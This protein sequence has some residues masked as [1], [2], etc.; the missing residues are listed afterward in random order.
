MGAKFSFLITSVFLE[1]IS[2]PNLSLFP[3]QV[4]QVISRTV[5]PTRG[6]QV[7]VRLNCVQEEPRDPQCYSTIVVICVLEGVSKHPDTLTS[8]F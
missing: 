5:S 4:P 3:I 2:I 6:L 1:Q 8:E 7:G